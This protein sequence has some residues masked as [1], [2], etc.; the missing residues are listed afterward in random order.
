MVCGEV[1]VEISHIHF[2]NQEEKCNKGQD[3]G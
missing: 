1:G 3:K 2:M